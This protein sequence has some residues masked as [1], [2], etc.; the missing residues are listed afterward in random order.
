MQHAVQSMAV[1]PG[2]STTAA[3]GTEGGWQQREASLGPFRG[4]QT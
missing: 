4:F 2:G 1:L 3:G